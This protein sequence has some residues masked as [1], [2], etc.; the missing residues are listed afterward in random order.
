MGLGDVYKRQG[1]DHPNLIPTIS[2]ILLQ[3]YENEIVSED[4]L[5]AW[6][7]KASKKYVDI[8]TSR[9]VRKQAETFLTW[10]EEA[11]SDDDEEE[12]SD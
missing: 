4:Q 11:E 6:G 8:S 10:L 7:Q 5:K 2:A 1:V 12:E 9:K 3:V